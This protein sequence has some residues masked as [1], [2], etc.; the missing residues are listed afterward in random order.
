MKRALA[1]LAL[2]AIATAQAGVGHDDP[3]V[4]TWLWVH[5]TEG[6][7]ALHVTP[8]SNVSLAPHMPEGCAPMSWLVPFMQDDPANGIE[9]QSLAREANVSASPARLEWH[10]EWMAPNGD[11]LDLP[12]PTMSIAAELRS[13]ETV[14][15]AGATTGTP[16][17]VDGERNVVR[18]SADLRW[19]V[20]IVPQ[21]TLWLAVEVSTL[22]DCAL[23][24][25]A[26]ATDPPSGVRIGA[27]SPLVIERI[28][29]IVGDS[30][31]FI[32]HTASPWGRA[33]VV[34]VVPVLLMP[35]G[36]RPTTSI[37]DEGGLE[38]VLQTWQADAEPINGT[39][40]LEVT[41]T[42]LQGGSVTDTVLFRIGDSSP[43][44][45]PAAPEP[46]PKSIPG[47]SPLWLLGLIGLR[48]R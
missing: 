9:P 36:Q 5:H 22:Q 42:S 15:A 44:P 23:P 39:Y 35:D 40:R 11:P 1:I 12:W 46:E 7:A 8:P 17:T 2:L 6:G 26:P 30:L 47:P 3:P 21:D 24:G 48:R 43:P 4:D 34:G 38:D 32:T 13:G 20:D 16:T 29:P 10:M 31:R 37:V 25:W 14:V 27:Y 33:D 28:D 18:L 45:A 41:A 19:E